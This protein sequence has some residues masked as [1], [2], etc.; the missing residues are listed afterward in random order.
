MIKLII[1][2]LD[3]VLVETEEIHY[4]SLIDSIS[5]N[6]N[7]TLNEIFSVIQ[8][9]GNST[10]TK[11]K[12]LKEKYNIDQKILEKIDKHKQKET[13]KKFKKLT[14]NKN[15]TKVVKKLKNEFVL[16]VV[17]NSRKEN[18]LYLLKKI[19]LHGYF[20]FVITPDLLA[21]K[22]SPAMY[23][24]AMKIFNI[25][26]HQTLILEDSELGIKSA[27]DSGAHVLVIN[28][29]NDTNEQNIFK[30]IKNI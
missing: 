26:A 28:N 30:Y 21:P 19:N 23:I 11:L 14:E 20:D 7:L 22:P 12:K 24:H 3:G 17:S 10:S 18:V 9:D 27:K 4:K 2:D 6:T 25:P 5:L 1:F 16:G 29:I 13:L 15:I 8:K